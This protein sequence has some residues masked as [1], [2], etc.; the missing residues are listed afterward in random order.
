MVEVTPGFSLTNRL[1]LYA[2]FLLTPGQAMSGIGSNLPTNIGFLAYNWYNQFVWYNAIKN[3]QLHALSLL[4]VHFNTIY[5]ITHLARV[6]PGN[7]FLHI[8]L[9]LGTPA[10]ML[11][12]PVAS[13]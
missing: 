4:P 12:N 10:L 5:A 13:W 11:F 9:G 8:T 6:S 1:L 3:N 7:L 2:S